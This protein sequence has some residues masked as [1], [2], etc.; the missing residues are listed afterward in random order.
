MYGYISH[1]LHTCISIKVWW[2]TYFHIM[3]FY[4]T[5]RQI[6]TRLFPHDQNCLEECFG[7]QTMWFKLVLAQKLRVSLSFLFFNFFRNVRMFINVRALSFLHD[8]LNLNNSDV[9]SKKCFQLILSLNR[10]IYIVVSKNQ[11][12]LI[13]RLRED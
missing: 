11:L 10:A 2:Y 9:I 1:T 5:T 7:C 3:V 4:K 8:F 6:Q 12:F 13:F